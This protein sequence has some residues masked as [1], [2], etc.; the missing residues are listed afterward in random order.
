MTYELINPPVRGR[1]RDLSSSD[2]AAYAKWFAQEMPRRLRGLEALISQTEPGKSWRADYSRESLIPLGQ[3]MAG[4]VSLRPKTD[5][6]LRAGAELSRFMTADHGSSSRELTE[7][8]FSIAFDVGLYLAAAMM[9]ACPGLRWSTEPGR[10]FVDY[11]QPVLRPFVGD[12]PMNPIRLAIV[13][14]YGLTQGLRRPEE[15]AEIYDFWS[16]TCE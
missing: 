12:V 2:R 6:E 9:E 16:N 7:E 4:Q 1:F 8:S 10:R 14:A 15:L 11:G 3:W 5:R 13:Q